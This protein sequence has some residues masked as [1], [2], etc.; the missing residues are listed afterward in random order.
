[1]HKEKFSAM[2][3]GLKDLISDYENCKSDLAK[4]TLEEVIVSYANNF[5]KIY[6]GEKSEMACNCKRDEKVI[7]EV[8]KVD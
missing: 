3:T 2:V 1:M 6:R 8:R 7:F 4:L 5:V